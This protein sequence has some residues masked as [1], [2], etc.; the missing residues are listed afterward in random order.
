MAS[1]V[2]GPCLDHSDLRAKLPEADLLKE[3]CFSQNQVP[4]V[5]TITLIRAVVFPSPHPSLVLARP[6]PPPEPQVQLF[7]LPHGADPTH[8]TSPSC[9]LL[10]TGILEPREAIHPRGCEEG[11]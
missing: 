4:L 2:S 10:G 3:Y 5:P 11:L 6:L 8:G 7:N 9:D 1:S